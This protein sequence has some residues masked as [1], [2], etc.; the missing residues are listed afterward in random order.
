MTPLQEYK[1]AVLHEI[2]LPPSIRLFYQLELKQHQQY[3][4]PPLGRSNTHDSFN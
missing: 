3:Y 4:Q 1:L 2:S